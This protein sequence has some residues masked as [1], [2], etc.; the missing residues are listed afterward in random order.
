[1]ST[2]SQTDRPE[3]CIQL[4]NTNRFAMKLQIAIKFI[5]YVPFPHAIS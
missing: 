3:F 1:M 5:Y 2:S 4:L